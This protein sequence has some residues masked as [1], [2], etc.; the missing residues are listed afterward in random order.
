[1]LAAFGE[2]SRAESGTDLGTVGSG[3]LPRSALSLQFLRSPYHTLC[4]S[5]ISPL[6]LGSLLIHLLRISSN[7]VYYSTTND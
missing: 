6:T 5:I 1:M 2:S 3:V 7:C 4:T